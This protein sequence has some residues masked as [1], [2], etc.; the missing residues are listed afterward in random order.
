MLPTGFGVAKVSKFLLFTNFFHKDGG[1]DRNPLLSSDKSCTLRGG[2][3]YGNII[4]GGREFVADLGKGLGDAFSHLFY[5]RSHFRF[6]EE[7]GDVRVYKA[8]ALV[9][10]QPVGS[11]KE[12]FAVDS[13]EF[14]ACVREMMPDIAEGKGSQRASQRACRA[15][16]PSE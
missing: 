9:H 1:I 13:L 4:D 12:D 5:E 3:L 11:F 14:R 7:D 6:L 2:G 10:N 15:T 8:V 16:S